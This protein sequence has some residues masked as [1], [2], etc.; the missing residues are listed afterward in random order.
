MHT[1]LVMNTQT[2]RMHAFTCDLRMTDVVALGFAV[3]RAT[4]PQPDTYLLLGIPYQV[5]W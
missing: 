2:K 3:L 4:A 5:E 1:L